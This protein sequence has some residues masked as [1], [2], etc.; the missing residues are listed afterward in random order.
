MKYKDLTELPRTPWF[1]NGHKPTRPG[2]YERRYASGSI[3]F[4]EWTGHNWLMRHYWP[5]TAARE[6]MVSSAVASWRGLA[7]EPKS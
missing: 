5:H 7:E 3:L 6:R 2:V 1:S 4:A